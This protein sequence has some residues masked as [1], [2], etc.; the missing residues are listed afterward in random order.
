MLFAKKIPNTNKDKVNLINFIMRIA[1]VNIPDNKRLEV[2]LTY[3]YGIGRS[4]AQ[5]ILKKANISF[6]KKAKDLDEKEASLIRGLVEQFKIEGDLRREIA[7]S[8]KR[9]KEIKCYRGIR[10]IKRL[11]VRGQRTCT[12]S[13]TIRGNVRIT[14]GSGRRKLEKK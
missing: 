7:S 11:P 14:L 4:R 8:I 2:A 9:L 13:R 6:D 3:I 5:E 10:H 1:G 12:N